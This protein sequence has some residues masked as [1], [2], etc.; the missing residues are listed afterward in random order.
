VLDFALTVLTYVGFQVIL[1]LG[2]NIQF[3]VAGLLNLAYIV[4]MAVGAYVT[5]VLMLPPAQPPFTHYIL[6]L[7]WP[8]PLAMIVGILAASLVAAALGAIAL[9]P[10][11]RK[12]YLA[13]A[14]LVSAAAIAQAVSQFRDLFNGFQGL[15]NIPQAFGSDWDPT[16]YGFAFLVLVAAVALVVFLLAERIRSFPLG[17]TLRAIREDELAA[18]S[19]GTDVYAMKLK[20]FV[21][22]A[23][24]AGAAG[25]LTAVYVTAFTTSGWA[26]G[27]TIV[28]LTC[29]FVGGA[30]NNWGSLIGAFFVV[31]VINQGLEVLVPLLPALPSDPSFTAVIQVILVNFLLILVLRWRPRGLLPERVIRLPEHFRNVATGAG[32]GG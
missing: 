1:T 15:I 17:R 24:I 13:I 14:T 22:G 8:F 16:L 30:G 26:I 29:V 19:F 7:R 9:G 31:A 25:A 10:R 2:L 27:E 18:R 5:A 23:A 21:I 32:D 3:G 6:G 20:A 28:A 11:L 4:F 12:E